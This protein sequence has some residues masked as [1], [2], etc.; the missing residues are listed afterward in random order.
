MYDIERVTAENVRTTG[1]AGPRK[2]RIGSNARTKVRR[3]KI[4]PGKIAGRENF[5]A[6]IPQENSAVTSCIDACMCA[7]GPSFLSARINSVT[8]DRNTPMLVRMCRLTHTHTH[9]CIYM[10]IHM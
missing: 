2:F 3:A 10:Y 1:V 7:A 6:E 4:R 8:R 9:E 5:R